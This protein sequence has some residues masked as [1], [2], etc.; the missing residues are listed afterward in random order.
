MTEF[1]LRTRLTFNN[2]DDLKKWDLWVTLANL[3]QYKYYNVDYDNEYIY[4][5]DGRIYESTC[6]SVSVY[7]RD[8]KEEV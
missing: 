2:A 4:G 1:T 6:N 3:L 7:S 5:I 8:E